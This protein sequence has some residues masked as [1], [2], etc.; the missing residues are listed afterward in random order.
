MSSM[1]FI[2]FGFELVDFLRTALS[3]IRSDGKKTVTER[4]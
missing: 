4:D 1:K 2:V 3:L